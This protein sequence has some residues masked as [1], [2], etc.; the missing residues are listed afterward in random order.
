MIKGNTTTP[1]DQPNL[2]FAGNLLEDGDEL[3]THDTQKKLQFIKL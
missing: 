1:S 2:V 3:E